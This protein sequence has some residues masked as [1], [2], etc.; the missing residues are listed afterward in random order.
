[1]A[2]M[3]TRH[4]LG[5]LLVSSLGLVGVGACSGRRGAAESAQH[6]AA[7]ATAA[8]ATQ[9]AQAAQPATT[10]NAACEG[11]HAEIAGE[12]RASLHRDS[13]S[14]PMYQRAFAREPLSFCTGCHAP[15]ANAH[16][17]G[18]SAT[19]ALGVGCV[20]CH[21]IT[22]E[23]PSPG[24]PAQQVAVGAT[25]D[26]CAH[27]HEFRFPGTRELMQLTV[28][29]HRAS[30]RAASTCASCHMP[31]VETASA[32]GRHASHRFDASRDASMIRS[33]ARIKV[34]RAGRTVRFSFEPAGAGHAFP[35]GDLFRRLRLVA[36]L[37][38]A[39][40]AR[41]IESFLGRKTKHAEVLGGTAVNIADDRPFARGQP[42]VAELDVGDPS[43]PIAWRVVYERVEHPRSRDESDAVVEGAIEVAAGTLE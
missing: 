10:R 6:R 25:N 11:C 23:H 5:L 3:P 20:T 42:T 17:P 12:W 39:G 13:H 9:A 18:P 36:D 35:T 30:P 2:S 40:E 31:K 29:E 26:A 37:R 24:R 7:A 16:D 22:G 28:T 15:E 32:R 41:H 38:G 19:H 34:A 1:M 14:D 21:Q 27:C 4:A 43:R 8:T 33:A